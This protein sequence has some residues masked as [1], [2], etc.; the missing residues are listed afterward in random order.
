MDPHVDSSSEDLEAT[1]PN[2]TTARK[3]PWR[4][5]AVGAG[6]LAA[7][8]AIGTLSWS[9][10]GAMNISHGSDAYTNLVEEK[11]EALSEQESVC[12]HLPF[13]RLTSIVSSNLGGDGPDRDK[14]EGIIYKAHGYHLGFN[15]TEDLEVHLH[16]VEEYGKYSN[17][18][19]KEGTTLTG[20]GV[21]DPE[22]KPAWPKENGIDGH[23]ASVNIKPGS[24]VTIRVHA[25]DATAKKDLEFKKFAITFF[26][27]DTGKDAKKSIEYVKIDGIDHFFTTNETEINITTLD[28]DKGSYLF[29]ATKEGNG[30]DNPKNP[31]Q[32]SELQKDRVFSIIASNTKEAKFTV[33]A[34]PGDTARVFDFVFRPALRCA[35]TKLADGNLVAAD[36]KLSPLEIMEGSASRVSYVMAI[37]A[38]AASLFFFN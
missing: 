37:L 28:K 4:V 8:A 10:Y 11:K 29:K 34:T 23:F 30:D 13:V 3:S 31:L 27:L 22:Y 25:Y 24:N 21:K 19:S 14:E 36:S 33:G 26:D 12:E 6:V 9:R 18:H 2:Q 7:T 38:A 16:A 5:L 35:W 17:H 20:G 32:L 15:D 1:I